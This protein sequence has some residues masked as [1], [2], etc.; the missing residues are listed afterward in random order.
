MSN[1]PRELENFGHANLLRE[2]DA[3]GDGIDG[4]IGDVEEAVSGGLG[5]L[6]K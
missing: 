5:D 1:R 6:R 4:F 2:S 3:A